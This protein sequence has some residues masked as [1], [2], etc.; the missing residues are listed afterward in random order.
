MSKIQVF[1][2]TYLSCGTIFWPPCPNSHFFHPCFLLIK[3][4]D[5]SGPSHV[6]SLLSGPNFSADNRTTC[7]PILM[8]DVLKCHLHRDAVCTLLKVLPWPYSS[9]LYLHN[10]YPYLTLFY[11]FLFSLVVVCPPKTHDVRACY[12]VN[13]V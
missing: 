11:A 3:L 10:I 5:T 13:H 7:C 9:L 6:L 12:L 2:I 1:T 8:I 4:P